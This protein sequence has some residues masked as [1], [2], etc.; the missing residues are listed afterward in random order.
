LKVI[1]LEIAICLHPEQHGW[2]KVTNGFVI[3]G[4]TYYLSVEYFNL[5]ALDP[6]PSL[7]PPFGG[8]GWHNSQQ[9]FPPNMVLN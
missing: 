6:I 2:R 4:T 5:I 8:H 1:Q 3:I 9:V 7:L